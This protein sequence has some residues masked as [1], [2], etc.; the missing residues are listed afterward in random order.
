MV[1]QRKRLVVLA[2]GSGTNLQALIDA[3]A[4]GRLAATIAR[5][6][7]DREDA[8]ARTR[9][10]DAG[11]PCD[12]VPVSQFAD[13]SAF[14]TALAAR[15]A[16]AEP[17]LVV[18]AGFM[19]ILGAGFIDRFAG[20][21]INLH[22][23]L[24]GQFPGAHAVR[25]AHAAAVAG[26]IT[27]TGVMVHYAVVE[28]D[29]GPVICQQAVAIDSDAPASALRERLRPVEHALIVRAVRIALDRPTRIEIGP[30]PGVGD[31]RGDRTLRDIH[32]L[33]LADVARVASRSVI[34][35]SGLDEADAKRL[36][37]ELLVDPVT[38]VATLGGL[39][40]A[41]TI[42]VGF[43]PGVTDS[44]AETLLQTAH[45]IGFTGLSAVAT[46]TCYEVVGASPDALQAVATQ[47]LVNP[48]IERYAIGAH[49]AP[50][51]AVAA[52]L[53]EADVNITSVRL[54]GLDDVGLAAVTAERRLALDLAEMRVIRD[55]YAALDRDPTDCELEMLAQ[56][57]SEHCAHKTFRAR[58]DYTERGADGRI[59]PAA[60]GVVDGLLETYIQRATETINASWVQSAFV[61]NAGIVAFD[62]ALS[63]AFKVETHNHPSALE[64]F[65]GANTGVGGVIRDIIGVSARPIA[66][67]DVLCFGPQDLPHSDVA[68]GGLHP[69]RVRDGVVRGVEDYGNKMGVPTVNG[70]VVYDRGY[71]SNPLVYV[72]CLGV[73]PT[74]SHPTAAQPGDRVVLLGGRTGRDG[75]RGA[76]FSSMGMDHATRTV[77]G[78]AVQIGHPLNEK[79]AL[80]VVIEAR[81]RG[82]YH[83]IT[84][85]GAGGLSSAVGEMASVL[86]ADVQ[87]ESV[88]LKYAG[89]AP[90]EIWLSEAQ[91]RM[92]LAVADSAW[93]ELVAIACAHG[94][95]C[96]TIGRFR[97]DGVLDVRFGDASIARMDTTFLHGGRPQREL[98]AEWSHPAPPEPEPAPVSLVSALL[99]TLADPNV[100]SKQD[101]VRRYDHEVQGGTVVKPFVGVHAD[102][103]SD[104]S[105]LV[106]F[107]AAAGT[108]GCAI[109]VAIAPH[110]GA[111][112]PY[113]MA[114][115]VVDEAVRNLVAVGGDPDQVSLLDN[116]CWGD[117]KKPD[118]LGALVRCVRGCHDAA[119][120][121]G[122]PFISGK[123]SLNNEWTDRDGTQR[124]IPHTLLI[125]ALTIV[126]DVTRTV[127]SDLKAAGNV[128]YVIGSTTDD[129]IPMPTPDALIGYRAL[130]EAITEGLVAACHD[131]SDGGLLT[132][133]AEMCIGGDI[134]AVVDLAAAGDLPTHAL[135]FA[136]CNGRLVVEVSP[137][138]A[139]AFE[140]AT[141]ARRIGHVG[142]TTL[143]V[144]SETVS[145]K[146]LRA[147]FG[148]G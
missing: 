82:L 131:V 72:G 34:V 4:D 120:A 128:L 16:V 103:P 42:D 68:D 43:H 129:W 92:V 56:T 69:R 93:D 147:A 73:L 8:Y 53:A 127:T 118:R 109:S 32:A 15:V 41:D 124:P 123:D 50:A 52:P 36:A 121:Y 31:P 58:I 78:G 104:A 9:A 119:V 19:R 22:P 107:E 63:L 132:A 148:V 1:A 57:W 21:V 38:E 112:D 105:V 88:P 17:H 77:A 97:D 11:I 14:D 54:R 70:A 95:D 141:V 85:C 7:V 18:L 27:H 28:V 45:A 98:V 114:W 125:S 136:E 62:E 143:R 13:R 66:C 111:R 89:L 116:F 67:T 113:A 46:G 81:D 108:R 134:G 24:P 3:C 102:G 23:A 5:V 65:G 6:V 33:G 106:P 39:P 74:G 29:A 133:I 110:L 84:D 25:Q 101:I 79:Q 60:S 2:S 135:A 139:A 37:A 26:A 91:E 75:I 49:V 40:H 87:L 138:S 115:A 99:D 145:V 100:A 30:K 20:R 117:P 59:D 144:G 86:G 146:A 94:S 140:A 76:T 10:A 48:V 126:P 61:D 51:L 90:W 142:G 55:H 12:I 35:V 80:E 83:A 122:A 96:T 64:P 137:S 44:T 130:H 47:L 71:V